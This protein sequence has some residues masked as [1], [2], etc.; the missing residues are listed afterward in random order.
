MKLKTGIAV[1]SVNA[2]L[3]LAIGQALQGESPSEGPSALPVLQASVTVPGNQDPVVVEGA[4]SSNTRGWTRASQAAV[5]ATEQG[6]RPELVDAYS[7]AVAASPLD[8]HLTVSLLAAIGQV[9]S[10]NLVGHHLDS[11]HRAVPA[12]LGPVLDGKKFA[13]IEDTD[14]GKLDG[15]KVWDRAVGPMQFVPASWRVAGV[16]MDGD[17]RRDPQ[18]VDDAAGT[19]MIYLCAGGR[20]LATDKGLN[21]AVLSYNHSVTYLRLVLAW[22]AVFDRSPLV[23]WAAL[24]VLD[25]WEQSPLVPAAPPA[26]TTVTDLRTNAPAPKS[27]TP[28]PG[29]PGTAAAPV[30]PV[31][32]TGTPGSSA[33][34]S[35]SPSTGS[36]PTAPASGQPSTPPTSPDPKPTPDPSPTPDPLPTCPVPSPSDPASPSATPDED[37]G[38]IADVP[39]DGTAAP[40]ECSPPI[41]PETG[42]PMAP[43]PDADPSTEPSAGGGG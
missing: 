22:K 20:D 10:G 39:G 33:T 13:A 6:I 11:E 1:L 5:A 37:G 8:C 31:P 28:S 32:M 16:D 23:G 42:L 18:D 27:G 21:D 38:F 35:T 25:A 3:A 26:A 34:P 4:L 17:G 43:V 40:V 19:A 9:E 30:G 24:P 41:D 14:R 36:T 2:L 12:I 15:D 7:L 29:T